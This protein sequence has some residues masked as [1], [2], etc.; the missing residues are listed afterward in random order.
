MPEPETQ[1]TPRKRDSWLRKLAKV[2][3]VVVFGPMLLCGLLIALPLLLVIGLFA[4]ICIFVSE[5]RFRARMRRCGRFLRRREITARIEAD[6]S[7]TLIVESPT[8]GWGFTRAWW[9]SES[10]LAFSPY[11]MPSDEDF[12][13]A[14]EKNQCLDWDRWHW[15][16]YTDPNKGRA[17]LCSVWSGR[18]LER[19]IRR[20]FPDT[21]VVH[22]WTALVY[23][24]KPA[25]EQGGALGSVPAISSLEREAA[26]Q[27]AAD[28][29][30]LV[31]GVTACVN[32]S[33]DTVTLRLEWKNTRVRKDKVL[34]GMYFLAWSMFA[35][36]GLFM[37]YVFFFSRVQG[38]AK[39]IFELCFQCCFF[40]FFVIASW[41]ITLAVSF[42]LLTLSW[43]E[44]IELSRLTFSHGQIGLWAPKPTVIAFDDIHE[45]LL[46]H[47]GDPGDMETC[48]TLNMFYLDPALSSRGRKMW[49]DWFAPELKVKVFELIEL[50]VAQYKIPLQMRITDPELR[51]WAS[52][53]AAKHVR[54]AKDN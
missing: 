15:E 47:Y 2:A 35:L 50:F 16:N 33:E 7:S 40:G 3:V 26:M 48:L 28:N 8:L 1:V 34:V 23:A 31:E 6:G 11:P 18:W 32:Q 53:R 46:G 36:A 41:A 14:A 37:I 42:R 17:F 12:R 44:W 45:L 25:A 21:S 13:G 54:S 9:T 19:R 43:R 29:L 10:V 49:G 24:L 30:E 5:I 20:R 4:A 51:P 38:M 52:E 22:T 27:V 39:G